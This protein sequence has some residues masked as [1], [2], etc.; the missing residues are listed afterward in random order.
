MF[1]YADSLVRQTTVQDQTQCQLEYDPDP[2]RWPWLHLPCWHPVVAE[3]YAYFSGVYAGIAVGMLSENTCTALTGMDWTYSGTA[4]GDT[5]PTLAQCESRLQDQAAAYAVTAKAASGA[6]IYQISGKG[7]IF[8]NRDFDAWRSQRKTVHPDPADETVFTPATAAEAGCAADA[9][10]ITSWQDS[11]SC[12]LARL[13]HEDGFYP[14]HPYHTGSGDHVNAA[15]LLDCAYQAAHAV[16][17]QRGYRQATK[18]PWACMHGKAR[19]RNYVELAHSFAVH[20]TALSETTEGQV[21]LRFD[22]Y[23][24]GTCC[25]RITL[26]LAQT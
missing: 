16:L 13:T 2:A 22:L 4:A 20:L 18:P 26:V 25:A 24:H 11:T 19:F 14:G 15:Q 7:V 23:Q 21:D 9:I 12:C 1:P 3:K 17:L 6:E 10:R 5:Y 8:R